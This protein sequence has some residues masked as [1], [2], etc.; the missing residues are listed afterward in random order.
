MAAMFLGEGGA[1]SS[2]SLHDVVVQLDGR[3]I[4]EITHTAGL[5]AQLFPPGGR[6]RLVKVGTPPFADCWAAAGLPSQDCWLVGSCTHGPGVSKPAVACLCRC[7]RADKASL[8]SPPLQM[9]RECFTH[10]LKL[11]RRALS[12]ASA[13]AAAAAAGITAAG[14]P[15]QPLGDLLAAAEDGAVAETV[16]AG[17]ARLPLPAHASGGHPLRAAAMPCLRDGTHRLLAAPAF[18]P[19]SD[20]GA[21]E[22]LRGLYVVKTDLARLDSLLPELCP[23]D[24][25]GELVEHTLR[26][27][28]S[29][30]FA[31]LE[32]R[33]L[34]DVAA[35]AAALA[36]AERDADADAQRRLLCGGLAALQALMVAGLER[37]LR[38]WG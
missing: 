22:L 15:L 32:R 1:G 37:L 14:Q 30:C 31:A 21:A 7:R 38:R 2:P 25:G 33:L 27:H 36:A 10:Y 24:R 9:C 4:T 19:A 16:A 20:W 23:H 13:I 34:G 12:D 18:H 3:F 5:F 8:P 17:A 26:Q 28:V 35:L 11:T 29:L 6:K